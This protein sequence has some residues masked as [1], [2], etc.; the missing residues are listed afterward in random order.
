MSEE[1]LKAAIEYLGRKHVLH[2]DYD[3]KHS[4][5]PDKETDIAKTIKKV[6][7]ATEAEARQLAQERI[8]KVRT[9]GG[10]R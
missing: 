7:K 9:I 8:L 6:T 3:G 5:M 10:K 2:P 1:K 4:F